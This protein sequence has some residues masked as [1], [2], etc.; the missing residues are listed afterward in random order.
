MTKQPKLQSKNLP[1]PAPR[2]SPARHIAD[3]FGDVDGEYLIPSGSEIV[4]FD[5]AK[6]PPWATRAGEE[7]PSGTRVMA[8][9]T[10]TATQHWRGNHPVETIIKKSGESLPDL[11]VLNAAIPQCEWE[12]GLNGE[13]R[14]PWQLQFAAYL[15]NPANGLTYTF[16]NSTIGARIAVERLQE[17]VRRMRLLRGT[18]VVPIVELSSAPMRTRNFG[19]KQRPDFKIVDWRNFGSGNATPQIGGPVGPATP[20]QELNDTIP[21]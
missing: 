2:Q 11:D 18:D 7:F 16:V 21:W 6:I 20:S 4:R 15:L 9:G 8:L 10:R 5:A 13:P 19:I 17:C 3:G 14:P 12:K 1:A